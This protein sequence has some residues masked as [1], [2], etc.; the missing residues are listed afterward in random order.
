M[1]LCHMIKVVGKP[2][3]QSVRQS[4]NRCELIPINFKLAVEVAAAR[5]AL[6]TVLKGRWP[7]QLNVKETCEQK[8]LQMQEEAE[9][10]FTTIR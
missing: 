10:L 6:E 2:V 3:R 5:R 9:V 4:M 7:P 8:D 1:S